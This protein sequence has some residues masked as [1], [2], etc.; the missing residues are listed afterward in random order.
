MASTSPETRKVWV[1]PVTT[2]FLASLGEVTPELPELPAENTTMNGSS[3]ESVSK[4]P[5]RTIRS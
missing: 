4:S 3:T 2:T 1:P 5:S